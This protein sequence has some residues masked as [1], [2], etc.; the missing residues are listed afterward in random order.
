MWEKYKANG[1]HIEGSASASDKVTPSAKRSAT[2]PLTHPPPSKVSK[3]PQAGRSLPA[4]AIAESDGKFA[5]R[6][7]ELSISG[8]SPHHLN[9][10]SLSVGVGKR[11]ASR[12]SCAQISASYL[13]ISGAPNSLVGEFAKIK[14]DLM[15]FG[16]A[17]QPWLP[18]GAQLIHWTALDTASPS[19]SVALDHMPHDESTVCICVP[20]QTPVVTSVPD[21]PKRSPPHLCPV[22]MYLPS[23]DG[24]ASPH[25]GYYVSGAFAGMIRRAKVIGVVRHYVWSPSEVALACQHIQFAMQDRVNS[26]TTA[27]YTVIVVP[28]FM[29]HQLSLSSSLNLEVVF[30]VYL[31]AA[32][33]TTPLDLV[34]C[35]HG[36]SPGANLRELHGSVYDVSGPFM[37]Y[38]TVQQLRNCPYDARLSP[39]SSASSAQDGTILKNYG[40]LSLFSS[41]VL[42]STSLAQ[43]LTYLTSLLPDE[44]SALLGSEAGW[45]VHRAIKLDGSQPDPSLQGFLVYSDQA[46]PAFMQKKAEAAFPDLAVQILPVSPLEPHRQALMEHLAVVANAFPGLAVGRMGKSAPAP[47]ISSDFSDLPQFMTEFGG[48]RTEFSLMGTRVEELLDRVDCMGRRSDLTNEGQAEL[49]ATCRELRSDLGVTQGRLSALEVNQRRLAE[50]MMELSPLLASFTQAPSTPASTT[51]DPASMAISMSTISTEVLT[52]LQTF[53]LASSSQAPPSPAPSIAVGQ[54][55]KE[56]ADLDQRAPAE[57]ADWPSD[58]PECFLPHFLPP[59]HDLLAES[60]VDDNTLSVSLSAGPDLPSTL[61]GP[62]YWRVVGLDRSG[63]GVSIHFPATREAIQMLGSEATFWAGVLAHAKLAV[64]LSC[65]GGTRLSEVPPAAVC[66][67]PTYFLGWVRCSASTTASMLFTNPQ[68]AKVGDQLYELPCPSAQKLRAVIQETLNPHR[69]S[70]GLLLSCFMDTS[71]NIKVEASPYSLTVQLQSGVLA[72]AALADSSAEECIWEALCQCTCSLYLHSRPESMDPSINYNRFNILH[73]VAAVLQRKSRPEDAPLAFLRPDNSTSKL[74][75]PFREAFVTPFKDSIP[76]DCQN[77]WKTFLD[78][79][80]DGR[81]TAPL[82]T[83]P[84]SDGILQDNLGRWKWD[85]P[86]LVCK[87]DAAVA[88][89][90]S[91]GRVAFSLAGILQVARRKAIFIVLPAP[92]TSGSRSR[93]PHTLAS[94]FSLSIPAEEMRAAL[95]A[96]ARSAA[97]PGLRILPMQFRC[98]AT[99]GNPS[100]D[101]YHDE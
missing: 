45:V 58:L 3:P 79:L 60:K 50:I 47:P 71:K 9:V 64:Y 96:E 1:F 83:F 81:T 13:I 34:E 99:L 8:G 10:V 5:D 42:R 29:S 101:S 88:R 76:P 52:S 84:L 37:L 94:V 30:Y 98:A 49:E 38:A 51:A 77:D 14:A 25:I 53:S 44:R 39:F 63:V 15:A 7:S 4:T 72:A 87:H 17:L 33:K 59:G 56:A 57:F 75:K 2:E 86:H 36:A 78:Y 26:R 11:L 66:W 93:Y 85:I 32:G 40:C 54:D 20:L 80:E 43:F 82:V 74:G 24:P 92:S 12:C 69:D 35:L 100:L 65:D 91:L 16:S 89:L 90:V 28:S 55:L 48:L 27:G 19:R 41:G 62:L 97:P 21:A 95:I 61:G 73:A 23:Q 22:V 68:V 70:L 46:L 6:Y 67:E 18:P 31:D